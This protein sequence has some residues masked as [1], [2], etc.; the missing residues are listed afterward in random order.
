[1]S[2]IENRDSENWA[3]I[4]GYSLASDIHGWVAHE[5]L[6]RNRA[7]GSMKSNS[8]DGEFMRLLSGT[9]HISTSFKRAGLLQGDKEA[10]I[11]D[12]SGEA[13]SDSYAEHAERMGFEILDDRPGLDIFDSERLGIEGEKSEN[14][15][16]GHIHLAD[17]R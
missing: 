10:W 1:M 3:L 6:M 11:V 9:H 7:R 12:L 15:A 4:S 16:I 2:W 14:G 8:L 13:S 17:L 5:V